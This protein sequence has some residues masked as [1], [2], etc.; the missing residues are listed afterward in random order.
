MKRKCLPA[1]SQV[2]HPEGWLRLM[3]AIQLC[4]F[5]PRTH[6]G[7][8]DYTVLCWRGRWAD[9]QKRET[10]QEREREREEE[11]DVMWQMKPCGSSIST[12]SSCPRPRL[13]L[14]HLIVLQ[15]LRLM[16]ASYSSLFFAGAEKRLWSK[17]ILNTHIR[18]VK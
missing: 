18:F 2:A 11:S 1:G 14:P 3:P 5:T 16:I 17:H 8:G 9:R 13:S 6:R 4:R 10:G 15:E 7:V 12:P